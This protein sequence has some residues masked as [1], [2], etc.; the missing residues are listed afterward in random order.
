MVALQHVEGKPPGYG[1][2]HPHIDQEG[3]SPVLCRTARWSVL[4][5]G[6]G[7]A[8]TIITPSG[9]APAGT[10]QVIAGPPTNG[11]NGG[12]QLTSP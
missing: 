4:L 10:F 9:G 12:A 7:V 8:Y 2:Q 1:L 11:D 6:W 5:P 3:I